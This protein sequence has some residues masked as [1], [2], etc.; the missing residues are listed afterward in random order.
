MTPLRQLIRDA[1]ERIARRY[2]EGPE[3]PPRIAD[4]ARAFTVAR[5]LA[6]V[7]DWEAYAV[8]LAEN[9]YRDG[10]IRGLE[11]SARRAEE[12]DGGGYDPERAREEWRRHWS[13]R[14]GH[15]DAREVLDLGDDPRDP[16]AGLPPA[17]RAEY[18]AQ[19]GEVTGEYRVVLDGEPAA[20]S[21]D[22]KTSF[23]RGG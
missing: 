4:E 11:A 20:S 18:L 12:G 23:H 1:A 21:T 3:P 9:A 15:P 22:G 5:P 14:E 8:E 7:A 16:L 6:T 13:A 19:L 10:F 2:Y 17:A